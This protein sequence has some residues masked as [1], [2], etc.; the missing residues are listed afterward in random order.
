VREGKL[1]MFPYNLKFRLEDL[2]EDSLFEIEVGFD[3]Q[4]LIYGFSIDIIGRVVKREYLY[5]NIS[6]SEK[7]I[8]DI[9]NQKI[10]ILS[11]AAS[12][13]ERV[14][15]YFNDLN[16]DEF[17]LI[18]LA[19]SSEIFWFSKFIYKWLLD[20]L[21]IITPKTTISNK[22]NQFIKTKEREAE[23]SII[24][25]LK[26]FDTGITDYVYQKMNLEKFLEILNDKKIKDGE[27]YAR[28]YQDLMDF[29]EKKVIETNIGGD[30]YRISYPKGKKE[31]IVELL[32]FRHCGNDEKYFSYDEESDGTKRLVEIVNILYSVQA[33]GKTFIIDEIERSF[34]SNLTLEFI[35]KFLNYASKNKGQLIITTHETKIMN[36]NLVRQDELWIIDRNKKG[37]SN[38]VPLSGFNIRADKILD[39]DYL[40]GRYGGVPN[41]LTILESDLK[42]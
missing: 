22:I 31:P 16:K 36:F 38:L 1:P 21:V 14:D 6:G 42:E 35:K 37:M 3:D 41:I 13:K 5:A 18:K 11:S 12:I 24:D 25:I 10:A 39:K 2:G 15:I 4:I 23:D 20:D 28:F 32:G 34:H 27:G 33:V 8:F 26:T 29:D 40:A 17:L 9:Q 7:L 19:E 30:F